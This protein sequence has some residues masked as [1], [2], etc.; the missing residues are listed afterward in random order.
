M[1]ILLTT[2]P[3]WNVSSAVG[4]TTYFCKENSF[5]RFIYMNLKNPKKFQAFEWNN[6]T[7]LNPIT[8]KNK[9]PKAT[10]PS[11]GRAVSWSFLG[12]VLFCFF[13]YYSQSRRQCS[14]PR[15]SPDQR[16]SARWVLFHEGKG[17]LSDSRTGHTPGLQVRS[18]VG[19]RVRDN[20][21]MFLSFPFSL[22]FPLCL[23]K[24]KVLERVY[25]AQNMSIFH[26]EWTAFCCWD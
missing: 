2:Y 18:P 24:E 4:L 12:F 21:P 23:K 1:V 20:R 10:F 14:S 25:S 11:I 15:K 8:G 13:S 3:E 19:A 22:P 17:C 16:G 26:A 6:S 9:C 7:T 5:F